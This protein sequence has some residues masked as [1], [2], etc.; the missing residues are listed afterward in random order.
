MSERTAVVTGATGGIGAAVAHRLAGDGYRVVLLGRRP[1]ALAALAEETGATWH[2]VDFADE[3]ALATIA[4]ICGPVGLVVH[5]VGTLENVRV[6]KQPLADFE[7]SLAANLGSA[8][9]VARAFG[10]VLSHGSRVV[11]VAST[12]ALASGSHLS[13]YAAG[14][15]GVRSLAGALREELEPAGIGVHVVMP[16]AVDTEMMS[17]TRVA[18]AA[19]LPADVAE[20]VRWLDSLPTRV[21]VDDLV[22]APAER[23]PDA[24]Q[25]LPSEE[26]D[27]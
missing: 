26:E 19:L 9:A 5:A 3:D 1:E 18:R 4:R 11:F 20:A 15:A 14:K 24:H 10:P 21:R 22:V 23:H 16:G 6:S 17:V 25:I 8:Y 7:R 27:R 2:R 13:A 12:A